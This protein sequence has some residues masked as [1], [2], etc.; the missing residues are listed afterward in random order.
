[1][2][3]Y[4]ETGAATFLELDCW[5]AGLLAHT[6]TPE[7]LLQASEFVATIE[8]RQGMK[9]ACPEEIACRED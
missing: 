2:R 4:R 5:G 3:D 1:M 6:T 7:M 8:V 9:I